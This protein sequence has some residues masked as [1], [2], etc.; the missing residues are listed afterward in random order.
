MNEI[1]WFHYLCKAPV[2][3]DRRVAVVQRAGDAADRHPAGDVG[4]HARRLRSGR[5]A[6]RPSAAALAARP[7]PETMTGQYSTAISYPSA[8]V[9][10]MKWKGLEISRFVDFERDIIQCKWP[11]VLNLWTYLPCIKVTEILVS[12]LYLIPLSS[13]SQILLGTNFL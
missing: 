13:S 6:A 12:F 3:G 9:I 8:T 5:A 7:E 1:T 2:L 4:G 10:R 11:P